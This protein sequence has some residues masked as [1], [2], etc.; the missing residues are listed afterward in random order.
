MIKRTLFLYLIIAIGIVSCVT[1]H[2]REAFN[3]SLEKYNHLVRWRDFDSAML[4]TS[5]SVSEEFRE[6]VIA[7]RDSRITDYQIV[8]VRYDDKA[9]EAFAVVNFSYYVLTSGILASVTDYQKW[10][11]VDEGGVKAW[12]LKSPLPEFR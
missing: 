7:A 1:E 9:R 12:R 5:A 3:M 11:Y 2:S 4:F 10:A 8:D 6:R